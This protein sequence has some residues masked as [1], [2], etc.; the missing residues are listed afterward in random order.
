MLGL[1]LPID[2][3]SAGGNPKQVKAF[4]SVASMQSNMIANAT[5]L[6]SRTP[7][8]AAWGWRTLACRRSVS[9][10]TNATDLVLFSLD[11]KSKVAT[12]TLNS[13]S[14]Y[15]ALTVEM[16]EAFEDIITN[17]LVP[18][19]ESGQINANSLVL[20][21]AGDKA[22]SAGGDL[23]WLK[24]LRHNPTHINVDNMMSFYRSF[25]CIRNLQIP[26]IAAI[27]G[28]AIGAGACLALG[29]D[30]RVA[31]P[32]SKLGF[33]F[34]TLGIHA[35][36]G[37]SHFLPLSVG[38]S[39]ANE[40]LLT[41]KIFTGEEAMEVGLVN[42]LA[43]TDDSVAVKEKAMELA[44][45]VAKQHPLAVR[46]MTKSIRLKEDEGLDAAL[47]REAYAQ[48][49]CYARG[50]WGEGIDANVERRDPVFEDYLSK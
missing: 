22:F 8:T 5:A 10:S 4:A 40:A 21:G 35:G 11:E 7:R 36:M 42:T 19:L 29:A 44:K 23:K 30:L 43:Q 6:A 16:G 2:W 45:K 27:H 13:P 14:T 41:G 38:R 47:Q 34:A 1:L 31:S 39:L 50:D 24:S 17:R 3:H 49:L 37:G 48:A 15:N 9:A 46:T 20:C 28:P 25:L 33:S 32:N 26:T 12:L 18:G